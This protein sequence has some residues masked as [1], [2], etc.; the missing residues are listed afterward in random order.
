MRVTLIQAELDKCFLFIL[1]IIIWGTNGQAN[2][3]LLGIEE[4]REDM[5]FSGLKSGK[6]WAPGTEL[7]ILIESC[8]FNNSIH[9][10]R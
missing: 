5:W 2:S 1:F 8:I 6:F 4:L 3:S 7:V 9:Y 10:Y